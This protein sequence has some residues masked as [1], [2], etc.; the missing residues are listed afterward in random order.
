MI[1]KWF[2]SCPGERAAGILP[3][4]ATVELPMPENADATEIAFVRGVLI[5]A[6]AQIWGGSRVHVITDEELANIEAREKEYGP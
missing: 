5:H 4:T 3:V 6:F 1:N 2:I